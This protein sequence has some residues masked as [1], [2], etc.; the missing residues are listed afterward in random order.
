M[1]QGGA[2]V[3]VTHDPLGDL[4]C[5]AGPGE[6][7]AEG[8][9]QGVEIDLTAVLVDGDD[10]HLRPL[11]R[12]SGALADLDDVAVGI[13]YGLFPGDPGSVEVI[14][15]RRAADRGREDLGGSNRR[16][17]LLMATQ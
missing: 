13:A 4:G 8:G 9:P 14:Q 10:P 15:H 3:A 16:V 6:L 2:V 7:G 17:L 5:D 12:A 1:L 11:G